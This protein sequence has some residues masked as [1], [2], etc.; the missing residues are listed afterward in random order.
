MTQCTECKTEL[1][2]GTNV[3]K[4]TFKAGRRICKRCEGRAYYA[5]WYADGGGR[6]QL[7]AKRPSTRNRPPKAIASPVA[8]LEDVPAIPN[9]DMTR[10]LIEMMGD[11]RGRERALH[12][13][14]IR[15]MIDALDGEMRSPIMVRV[16]RGDRPIAASPRPHLV[17]ASQR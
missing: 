4:L 10:H 5:A 12:C 11:D 8:A 13:R 6:E 2:P 7:A 14:K 3:G 16:V 17:L 1:V 15:A 9:Q